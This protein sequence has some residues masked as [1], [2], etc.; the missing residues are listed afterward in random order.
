MK[1]IKLYFRV[2]L[3]LSC[4]MIKLITSRFI[5]HLGSSDGQTAHPCRTTQ[6]MSFWQSAS[7]KH[8]ANYL[9]RI[10]NT[11]GLFRNFSETTYS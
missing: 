2:K 5:S 11:N 3:T 9:F 8:L 1:I 6:T 4:K 10:I 7:K